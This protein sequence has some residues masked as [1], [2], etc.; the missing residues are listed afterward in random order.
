[1]RLSLRVKFSGVTTVL[2]GM[3]MAGVTGFVYR[4]EKAALGREVRE[5]G[6]T[7][8][9]NLAANAA[10]AIETRDKLKLAV[11]VKESVQAEGTFQAPARPG[12]W[13]RVLG[14][15]SSHRVAQVLKNEGVLEAVILD[16]YSNTAS[17]SATYSDSA[18]SQADLPYQPPAIL[19]AASAA[20]P[21]PVYS[22][23]GFRV[24]DI[25]VPITEKLVGKSLGSVHLGMRCDLIEQAVRVAATK[26]TAMILGMLLL[27]VLLTLTLVHSL[28][29]P[30]DSLVHGVRAV[31]EGDFSRRITRR[32]RDE[33]GDLIE[34]YNGMAKSLGENETLKKAFTKYTSSSLMKDILADP[35]AMAR[36][37]G[38]RLQATMFF[39]LIHGLHGVSETMDPVEFVGMLNQY[40]GVQTEIIDRC[41]GR[42]DKFVR[43]EVM[44]VW[45]V[46]EAG[47]DDAFQAVR[48][49]VEC[50]AA[51]ARLNEERRARQEPVF[52]VSIGINTG[53]VVS[54]NMGSQTKMDYTVIGDA[55]NVSARL[56]A[57]GKEGQVML[58][59]ATYRLVKDRIQAEKLSPIQVK[60]KKD[61]LQV[62]HAL[63]VSAGP[64]GAA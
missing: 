7:I 25:E 45:G 40:L 20:E 11:L 21:Y 23:A 46:P 62:Y 57:N 14:D 47:P 37:G 51:L 10:D 24:F 38:K 31:S 41:G 12:F 64:K 42:I 63:A 18:R 39:S 54:G 9:R 26:M 58:S 34:A 30:V 35:A 28:V 3:M 13:P 17:V 22:L 56:M 55:V 33:L 60:G 19:E 44:A 5:R 4:Q 8:A 49:A 61:P 53:E 29:K 6:A 52:G 1:M 36:L 15:L 50:Q 27:G 2:I 59:E 16:T 43:E 48:A 32:S